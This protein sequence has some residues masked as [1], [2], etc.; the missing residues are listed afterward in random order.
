LIVG[1]LLALAAAEDAFAQSCWPVAVLLEV[2]DSAGKRVDPT[3]M[4]SVVSDTI[5][6]PRPVRVR[7]PFVRAAAPRDR[8]TLLEWSRAG[9]SIQLQRVTLYSGGGAMHLEF[10]MHVDSELRRGPSI[11]VVQAPPF[12]PGTFRL[13]FH[14]AEPGGDSRSPRRLTDGRWKPAE[15]KQPGG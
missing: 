15:A 1:L 4:D 7:A 2:R 8:S 12:Q 6:A 5:R 10:D 11:F 14:P 3:T 13:R 9:C